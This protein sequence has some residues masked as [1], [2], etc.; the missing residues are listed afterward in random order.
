[1]RRKK[2]NRSPKDILRD[3]AWATFSIWIR[4]RDKKCV[5]CGSTTTPQ[6]GHFWHACL[7][8]DEINI[9]QQCS[10]CNKFRS[11]NLAVYST[12]LINKYG[13]KEFKALEKRHYMA[14]KGEYRTEQ[15]YLNLIKKYSL[16]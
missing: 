11:G 2:K 13:I 8:F 5:T 7:D 3:K 6:A 9:N 1:M 16:L 14:M 12:Y 15:D 10:G 4:N